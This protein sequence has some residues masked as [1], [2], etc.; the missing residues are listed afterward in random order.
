MNSIWNL[1]MLQLEEYHPKLFNYNKKQW[2][3]VAI[4]MA[5]GL[6][7]LTLVY[8]YVVNKIFTMMLL[9]QGSEALLATML[10]IFFVVCTISLI[11]KFLKRVYNAKDN[12]LFVTLPISIPP[13][14]AR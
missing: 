7:C 14:P 8:Y 10:T 6:L 1:C 12:N 11:L 13:T 4:L 2:F 9:N 5:T 3:V